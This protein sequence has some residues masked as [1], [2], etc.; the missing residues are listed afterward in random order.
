[1]STASAAPVGAVPVAGTGMGAGA[2]AAGAVPGVLGDFGVG[3]GMDT[4]GGGMGGLGAAMTGIQNMLGKTPEEREKN[5]KALAAGVK[6]INGLV[7]TISETTLLQRMME[8]QGAGL[9]FVS[10]S[11]GASVGDIPRSF[12]PASASPIMSQLGFK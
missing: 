10:G 2:P 3:A 11:P 5:A 1:M 8:A 12:T 7:G 6:D 4:G 9:G